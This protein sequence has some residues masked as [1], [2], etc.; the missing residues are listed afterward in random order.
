MEKQLE[1]HNQY[2]L[3]IAYRIYPKISREPLIFSDDKFQL[4]KF[5]LRSFTRSLGD[6]KVKIWIILDGCPP[7]YEDLVREF[8]KN[9]DLTIIKE[10]SIGNRAT[11]G[12]QIDLLTKQNFSKNVYFAEDDYY[13]FPNQFKK[14]I[15]FLNRFEDVDFVTPY[16]HLDYYTTE[17]H[18]LKQEIRSY[19]S[20]HWRTAHSTFLTFL[21]TKRTLLKTKKIFYKYATFN[22]NKNNWEIYYW[23]S[24]TKKKLFNILEILRFYKHH[25]LYYYYLKDSWKYNWGPILFARKRKLWAPIPTIGTHM[26]RTHLSPSIDWNSIF[27]QELNN[28]Q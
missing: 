20:H 14:M 22:K 24:I 25:P 8:F 18:N 19:A 17:L 13:Y 7:K 3:A 9:E 11:F 15:S 26:E 21:T 5:C 27:K 4:V 12:L 6:L 1:S 23:L 28:F 16:D 2:D 10:D